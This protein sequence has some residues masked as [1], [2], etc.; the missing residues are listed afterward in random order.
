MA[1]ANEIAAIIAELDLVECA[2][3]KDVTRLSQ[4]M[5]RIC[6]LFT[7]E[8]MRGLFDNGDEAAFQAYIAELRK[9]RGL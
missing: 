8:D 1:C 6:K 4:C 2:R 9:E 3:D 5:D 7:E